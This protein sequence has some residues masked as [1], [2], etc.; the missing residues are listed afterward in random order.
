[1]NNTHNLPNNNKQD[2]GLAA[3]LTVIP[4]FLFWISHIFYFFQVTTTPNPLLMGKSYCLCVSHGHPI[5]LPNGWLVQW[6]VIQSG[7]LWYKRKS[8]GTWKSTG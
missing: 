2:H 4:S 3:Y 5:L 1:M 6:Q 8:N 7:P